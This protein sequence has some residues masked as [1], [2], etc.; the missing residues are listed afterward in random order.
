MS[1]E[2]DP[3][4]ALTVPQREW[5]RDK[6]RFKAGM[7]SRQSGKTMTSTLEL[8]L[9]AIEKEAAGGRARWV[10]LSRGERQAKEAITEGVQRH[11]QALKMGFKAIEVPFEGLKESALEVVLP[12]GSRITG[13]P[14][15]PD[16]A[17]GFTA[18]CLLD[19]FAFHKDSGA[20]WKALFPVVSRGDLSLRVISTPNGKKN[21]FY[22]LMTGGG[23]RTEQLLRQ[24]GR[25]R[26]G[27]WSL[28]FTD[29][30]QAVA[31][32]LPRNIDELR[33]GLDDADAWAQEYELLWL[34]AAS[35]WLDMELITSCEDETA[36]DPERY[37]GGRV[38]V[39][40][41]IATRRDLFVIWVLELVGDVLWTR[42]VVAE[43]RISFAA[44][45]ELLDDV[46]QRFK[47]EAIWIDQT[48]LGEKPVEDAKRRYGSRVHG[49]IFTGAAKQLLATGG[50]Q[51]FEG[52]LVRIP[53][54]KAVRADLHKLKR[55]TTATGAV[56]FSAD[57]DASGHADRAWALFLALEA[58]RMGGKG[59][60]AFE[61]APA[62]HQPD[63][64][65]D[66]DNHNQ[67]R[68]LT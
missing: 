14:A 48:G 44:Q 8:V 63:S 7:V 32:G 60:Y 64:S 4:L 52:H 45:D 12:G 13:L 28:H 50:K 37:Q 22:E 30:Y 57:S 46:V 26:N 31:A 59:E 29:I 11:L 9:D 35:S 67:G 54:S 65:D 36:G 43:Q 68:R 34:D 38:F 15:N 18:S 47:P 66:D 40:V 27:V 55:E 2:L 21:K 56:R 42:E 49:V 17:R 51:Q 39:G 10:I 25:A 3:A 5:V 33:E 53:Q 41:D 23:E 19:E 6:S 1:A 16:T 61:S 20:I 58:A 24:T 62:R